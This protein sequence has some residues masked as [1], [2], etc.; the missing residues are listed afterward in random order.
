MRRANP[1]TK[2]SLSSEA[3][4]YPGAPAS[5]CDIVHGMLKRLTRIGL[6]AA[7]FSA[8]LSGA[9]TREWSSLANAPTIAAGAEI[10]AR[11]TGNQRI[12]GHFKAADNDVLVID[13]TSGE[14]RLARGAVS[15]VS[16][17]TR[18]HR[19]RNTLIGFGIGA[20]SGLTVGAIA[21]ARCAKNCFLSDT[22]FG[23]EVLTPLGALIGTVI[24]AVVPT[25][26]WREVYRAP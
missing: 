5:P 19:L 24:G 6:G 2:D 23:K 18:G 9:T 12:R 26:G 16:V 14:Q 22:P 8:M 21:D 20:A 3:P 15:R 25:G 7:L 13:T 11:T 10:E 1:L 17:K 4:E